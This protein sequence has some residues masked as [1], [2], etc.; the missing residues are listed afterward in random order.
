M[1]ETVQFTEA[2]EYLTRGAALYKNEK[3]EEA[4]DCYLKAEKADPKNINVYF[5]EGEAYV[6]LEKYEEAAKTFKKIILLDKNNGLAYFHLGN[7]AFLADNPMEGREMYAKAIKCGYAT[8]QVYFNLATYFEQEGEYDEAIKNYNKAIVRDPFVPEA[9]LRKA[10]IYINTG[11]TEQAV[12]A[13]D[14][15]IET[16][17][18]VFEGYHYKF[19]LLAQAEEW[20]RAQTV[21]ETALKLFPDDDGFIFDKILLYEKQEKFDEAL[22][23]IE[24]QIKD[25]P[26]RDYIKEKAKIYLAIGKKDEAVKMLEDIRAD[27][28]NFD[29]ESRYFLMNIYE[30]DKNDEAASKC[31]DEIVEYG[32]QSPYY[33]PAVYMRAEALNRLSGGKDTSMY[34]EAQKILRSYSTVYAERTDLFIYRALCYNRLGNYV[35]AKEMAEYVLT[36]DPKS[37][38]AHMALADMYR[39]QG[40]TAHAEEEQKLA[41]S[42]S[43]N[44]S[45]LMS[46]N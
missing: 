18:D 2:E 26:H 35:R 13:L 22:Q 24:E 17:P 19:I 12:Q 40:D 34:E 25:N 10:E 14:D 8:Y 20:T 37:G 42:L 46:S 5:K 3:Y 15:L 6:M 21:L 36:L 28:E 27:K 44:L 43:P 16:N 11:R 7:T 38:E 32:A 4:L 1:A 29:D 30:S 41:V 45:T 39:R 31:A 9:K 23:I 33:F